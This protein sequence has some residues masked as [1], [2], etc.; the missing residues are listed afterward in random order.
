MK[1]LLKLF[2]PVFTFVILSGTS[3][4][5][6]VTTATTYTGSCN[7]TGMNTLKDIIMNFVIGCILTRIVF[8]LIA[9]SFI[10]FI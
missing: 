3:I 8:L 10:T 6:A 9:V 5:A 1:K 4:A 2:T 7:V